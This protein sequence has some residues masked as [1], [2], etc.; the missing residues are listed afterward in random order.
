MRERENV[1]RH[2]EDSRGRER[3][4]QNVSRAREAGPVEKSERE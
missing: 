4:R 3:S 1:L 2:P